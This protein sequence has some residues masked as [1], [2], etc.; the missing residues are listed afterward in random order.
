M[1]SKVARSATSGPVLLRVALE[2]PWGK[3]EKIYSIE[4]GGPQ[5][6]AVRK[7]PPIK[8]VHIRAFSSKA[9]AKTLQMFRQLQHP[10]LVSALEA[11]TTDSGLHIVFEHMPISLEWIVRSPAFPDERQLAALLG[12]VSSI[13]SS[14]SMH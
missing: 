6:V 4:L 9:S 14:S 11:F 12:Q 2:P 13:V 8:L 5:E 3:Y 7:L 1:R 10:N